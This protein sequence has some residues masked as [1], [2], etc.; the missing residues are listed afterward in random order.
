[1]AEAWVELRR[2]RDRRRDRC[3]SFGRFRFESL[4]DGTWTLAVS[5]P[6]YRTLERALELP[7]GEPLRLV[8][9]RQPEPPRGRLFGEC[10]LGW[11][12]SPVEGLRLE[13]LGG[14]A[15]ELR[16]G[17]FFVTGLRPGEL[18]LAASAVGT[19]RLVLPPVELPPGG[20]LD[21]GTLRLFP[22][23]TLALNVEG[24]FPRRSLRARLEPLERDAGGVGSD[25]PPIQAQR[26]NPNI[27]AC[28]AAW[29]LVV[30][31]NGMAPHRERVVLEQAFT[32]LNVRLEPAE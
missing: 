3:G 8:L 11:S 6:G 7:I 28:Q 22:L 15:I 26:G 1:V 10:L 17:R 16:G 32:A 21:L 19:E 31:A 9:E 18:R 30:E 24:N 12:S 13:G 29:E 23:A 4:P 27:R 14:A 5:A 25:R 20:N 2:E